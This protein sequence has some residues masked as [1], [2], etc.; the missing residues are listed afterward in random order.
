MNIQQGIKSASVAGYVTNGA[1]HVAR[2][3]GKAIET[4]MK[5]DH[6]LDS[7]SALYLNATTNGTVTYTYEK[8]ASNT[9][10]HSYVAAARELCYK[11]LHKELLRAHDTGRRILIFYAT[12]SD[13]NR[14]RALDSVCFLMGSLD[15]KDALR[16][17]TVKLPRNRGRVF[18]DLKS[19]AISAAQDPFV[20]AFCA[21]SSY[22]LTNYKFV[23]VLTAARCE[24]AYNLLF[25]PSALLFSGATHEE[26]G[27]QV[28]YDLNTYPQNQFF[29]AEVSAGVANLSWTS[30]T[31]GGEGSYSHDLDTWRSKREPVFHG[32]EDWVNEE[33]FFSADMRLFKLARATAPGGFDVSFNVPEIDKHHLVLDVPRLVATGIGGVDKEWTFMFR[34]GLK[35]YYLPVRDAY[36]VPTQHYL[37]R[38]FGADD[39]DDKVIKNVFTH[40]DKSVSGEIDA[41]KN[42]GTYFNKEIKHEVYQILPFLHVLAKQ[43]NDD[44]IA[45]RLNRLKTS[46]WFEDILVRM[47]G[48]HGKLDRFMKWWSGR[49]DKQVYIIRGLD[50][51]NLRGFVKKYVPI[52]LPKQLT[53]TYQP[54]MAGAFNLPIRVLRHLWMRSP[55]GEIEFGLPTRGVEQF[56]ALGRTCVDVIGMGDCAVE[57]FCSMYGPVG[58]ALEVRTAGLDMMKVLGQDVDPNWYNRYVSLPTHWF[59]AVAR[60]YKVD[61][62]KIVFSQIDNDGMPVLTEDAMKD[63]M[64]ERSDSPLVIYSNGHYYAT[65]SAEPRH[66]GQAKLLAVERQY[67]SMF[68]PREKLDVYYIGTG[69]AFHIRVLLDEFPNVTIYGYDLQQPRIKHPRFIF[70]EKLFDDRVAMS[71]PHEAHYI[72]DMRTVIDGFVTPRNIAIDNRNVANW[73]VT[74]RAGSALLKANCWWGGDKFHGCNEGFDYPGKIVTMLHSDHYDGIEMR[75]VVKRCKRVRNMTPDEYF[76]YLAHDRSLRHNNEYMC[77]RRNAPSFCSVAPV[78]NPDSDS[79]DDNRC[80]WCNAKCEDSLC[81]TCASASVDKRAE[82]S[83]DEDDFI[84]KG[85]LRL[86]DEGKEVPPNT[87]EFEAGKQVREIDLDAAVFDQLKD[88]IMGMKDEAGGLGALGKKVWDNY[89]TWLKGLRT[90]KFNLNAVVVNGYAGCGKSELIRAAVA[91]ALQVGKKVLILLPVKRIM[92]D[93]EQLLSNNRSHLRVKTTHHALVEIANAN[94][95]PDLIF[96]D[97]VGMVDADIV[98]LIMTAVPYAQHIFVGDI[99]QTRMRPLEGRDVFEWLNGA[100]TWW[101]TANFRNPK[102]VVEVANRGL[103]ARGA[104]PMV[105]MSKREG[106]IMVVDATGGID[107]RAAVNNLVGV[108]TNGWHEMTFANGTGDFVFPPVDGLR[109]P[110]VRACQGMTVDDAILHVGPQ[111]S[112]LMAN[113]EFLIV[114]LTRARR[115]LVVVV[116]SAGSNSWPA[117]LNYWASF[118]TVVGGKSLPRSLPVMKDVVVDDPDTLLKLAKKFELAEHEMAAL[119]GCELAGPDGYLVDLPEEDDD[120]QDQT[121][122]P[123]CDAFDHYKQEFPMMAEEVWA[124]ERAQNLP[125]EGAHRL[126]PKPVVDMAKG[127]KVSKH[128]MNPIS[129][130]SVVQLNTEA[131]LEKTLKARVA[132][133][134]RDVPLTEELVTRIETMIDKFDAET[135]GPAPAQTSV[136]DA[137]YKVSALATAKHYA[138]RF[139]ADLERDTEVIRFKEM[140]RLPILSAR[141]RAHVKEQVKVGNVNKVMDFAKAGQSINTVEVANVLAFSLVVRAI[142]EADM[143]T[144]AANTGKDKILLKQRMSDAKFRAKAR[145]HLRDFRNANLSYADGVGMDV[146]QTQAGWYA[147]FYRCFKLIISSRFMIENFANGFA[148]MVDYFISANLNGKV[149]GEF[150]DAISKWQTPS[151]CSFTFDVTTFQSYFYCWVLLDCAGPSFSMHGGDDGGKTGMGLRPRPGGA[152]FL[153]AITNVSL[154]QVDC[155]DNYFE[156][157]GD[158]VIVDGAEVI[159]EEFV[160]R[161]AFKLLRARITSYE[162]LV[163]LHKEARR[164]GSLPNSVWSNN[165]KA[166]AYDNNNFKQALRQVDEVRDAVLSMGRSSVDHLFAN[167]VEVR[168]DMPKSGMFV[169]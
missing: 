75:A 81:D 26:D 62:P 113:P 14:Y 29:D 28:E 147:Y 168:M 142:M 85:L 80:Q 63:L 89:E 134:T 25:L 77:N 9:G 64:R 43:R 84:A 155:T 65:K 157:C 59:N 169:C 6:H 108:D 3:F 31:G 56:K 105:P 44:R 49:S 125:I 67:L 162:H 15:P 60:H 24:F 92:G 97:E 88:R 4:S 58:T 13:I 164:L 96:Y 161:K 115:N 167:L 66:D 68:D 106:D 118:S 144:F 102:K 133:V 57:A 5:V 52:A 151:G 112:A 163:E 19:V 136:F 159:I 141:I 23:E 124:V 91:E 122:K 145:A 27:I 119:M 78:D 79:S 138:N 2:A 146:G 139:K 35:P 153:E 41:C 90:A 117:G 143:A 120:L 87:Y 33:I 1:P 38:V 74:A 100:P 98:K 165:A 72:V 114:A 109:M 152:A 32:K 73:L 18:Y 121:L 95:T 71:M 148:D 116:H 55:H 40:L 37:N 12:A 42:A 154:L 160:F 86:R 104:R 53:I 30:K 129:D 123:G 158:L 10:R 22:S 34:G 110:S 150:I 69:D 93:Y 50:K 45:E 156:F 135:R 137:V 132:K 111:C 46:N 11:K 47:C 51:I 39:E 101:F 128:L 126:K 149:V 103:V 21:D 36:I 70:E 131:M 127:Q 140:G 8:S 82:L 61:P 107:W 166:L 17:A 130:N 20:F 48:K 94:F 54:G 83:S 7:D 16:N 99:F 76:S